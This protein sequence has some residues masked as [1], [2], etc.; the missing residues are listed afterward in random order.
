MLGDDDADAVEI[1]LADWI[2]KELRTERFRQAVE[3]M[4]TLMQE[5]PAN[6][7]DRD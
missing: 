2:K 4:R 1:N 6:Q 5:L 7:R 3:V